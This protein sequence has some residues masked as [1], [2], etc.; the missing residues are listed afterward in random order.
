MIGKALFT[1]RLTASIGLVAAVVA[2]AAQPVFAFDGRSPDTKS[3]AAAA[4]AASVRDARS[5][6]TRSASLSVTGTAVHD[7]RDAVSRTTPT[8]PVAA[9]APA[10][11]GF[12]WGDFGVG[13]GA[14]IASIL[15]LGALGFA[16]WAGHRRR[17]AGTPALT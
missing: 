3:A 17:E 1:R 8:A 16:F 11:T 13:V 7:F 14:A 12:D 4:T 5:P 15:L 9:S 10:S 2:L 6:D